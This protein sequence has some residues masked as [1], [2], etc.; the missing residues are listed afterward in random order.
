M[1][2][3]IESALGLNKNQKILGYL[4]VG[5]PIGKIKKIPSVEI[6]KFVTKLD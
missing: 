1:N 5:T 2:P 4:Y 3:D 6:K